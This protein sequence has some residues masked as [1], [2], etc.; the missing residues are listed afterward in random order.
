MIA[1]GMSPEE[2]ARQTGWRGE[3]SGVDADAV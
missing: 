1:N 3:E 2:A